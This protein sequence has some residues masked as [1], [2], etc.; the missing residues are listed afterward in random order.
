[1]SLSSNRNSVDTSVNNTPYI[2]SIREDDGNAVVTKVMTDGNVVTETFPLTKSTL[3]SYFTYD[4]DKD[5]LVSNKPVETTLASLHLKDSMTLATSFSTLS[6]IDNFKNDKIIPCFTKIKGNFLTS[7]PLASVTV[8]PPKGR[9]YM[10]RFEVVRYGEP[11]ENEDAVIETNVT[12][13]VT[14]CNSVMGIQFIFGE[15]IVGEDVQILYQITSNGVDIFEQ[16]LPKSNYFK[17]QYYTLT[18]DNA[19]DFCVDEQNGEIIEIQTKICKINRRTREVIG[20]L[21]TRVASENDPVDGSSKPYIK[22]FSRQFH[23]KELALKETL[24]DSSGNFLHSTTDASG[25]TLED[26]I[27]QLEN[28]HQFH[29]IEQVEERVFAI[30]EKMTKPVSGQLIDVEFQRQRIND[31]ET[32]VLELTNKLNSL[33]PE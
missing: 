3:D 1:M 19:L 29:E 24:F 2:N 7:D 15:D 10:D 11:L 22:M 21:L 33:M 30:E 6:I 14:F 13:Y 23:D 28:H 32:Q 9:V 8:E 26:R 27:L 18:W 12:A 31:L 20:F 5:R 25:N 4:E 16:Y 17:N